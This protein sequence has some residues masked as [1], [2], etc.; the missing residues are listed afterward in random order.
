MSRCRVNPHIRDHAGQRHDGHGGWLTVLQRWAISFGSQYRLSPTFLI[1]ITKAVINL[2]G[3]CGSRVLPR[4]LWESVTG[5]II[6]GRGGLPR[7]GSLRA[8]VEDDIELSRGRR[9]MACRRDRWDSTKRLLYASFFG[10]SIE[11]LISKPLIW[12][13]P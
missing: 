13:K 5:K 12:L 4:S 6:P 2:G 10:N 1:S 7:E 11:F 8:L 3:G 9:Q